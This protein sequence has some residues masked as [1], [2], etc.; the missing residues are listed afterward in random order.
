[1]SHAAEG[2]TQVAQ[3]DVVSGNIP[4]PV[5]SNPNQPISDYDLS[6]HVNDTPA[7][8]LVDTGAAVSLISKQLWDRLEQRPTLGR[9]D[10]KLVGVQGVPLKVCGATR[11]SLKFGDADTTHPAEVHVVDGITS[12]VI[13]G[14]D[15]L[16]QNNC[17]VHLGA[18]NQLHLGTGGTTVCLG[19]DIGGVGIASVD[20]RLDK[21]LEVPAQSEME[22]V[23][24]VPKLPTLTSSSWLVEP[25][26]SQYRAVLPARAVVNPEGGQVPVRVFNPRPEPVRVRRGATIARMEPLPELTDTVASV[27]EVSEVS[28]EKQGQ[29]WQTVAGG[30]EKLSPEEQR[31]LYAVLLEY[32]DLFADEP[33]DFG[34]TSRIKHR[35]NIGDAAPIRQRVRRI[36]PLHRE[37]ARKLLSEMLK[38]DV[39]QPSSSPWASPIVLVQKKDGSVRFCVDYRKVNAVTRKDAYP[40]PRV[41]DT[42]D[43]LS[44][45]KWFSTLDLISGYW[46]VEVDEKDREKTAFCMPEG[47]FEFKVMP[48]GLCNAPAT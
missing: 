5:F 21:N 41:D 20:L 29:L 10:R 31:Q 45:S 47:L 13:L 1:M 22:I 40:L 18:H 15:F 4:V 27:E 28:E 14:R 8:C 39:I 32:A 23:V 46:Q 17:S 2:E 43:T 48:F 34:R 30:C 11:V 3:E 42:L 36:P 16:K 38:K 26:A 7:S 24:T 12:D 19:K 44:G 37:E 9:A 33:D 25:C 35:I 6:L